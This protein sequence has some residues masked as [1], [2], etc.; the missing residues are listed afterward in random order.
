[1]AKLEMNDYVG[2]IQGKKQEAHEKQ[3]LYIEVNAKELMEE[4]EP[5]V[6]NLTTACKAML[7]MMLEGDGFIVEPKS[8]SKVAG[9]LTVRYYVDNLSPERRK[10]SEVN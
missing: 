5:G 10:Y 1:M 9:A 6:K 4:L 7:D 3:W 2:A 8:K